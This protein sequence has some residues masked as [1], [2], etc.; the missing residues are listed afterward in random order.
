MDIAGKTVSPRRDPVGDKK[1]LR[2]K[3][4]E[5]GFGDDEAAYDMKQNEFTPGTARDNLLTIL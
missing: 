3:M 1:L 2:E 4:L 5:H